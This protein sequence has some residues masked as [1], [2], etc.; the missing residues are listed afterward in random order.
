M[1]FLADILLWESQ[2]LIYI[3]V[4][5]DLGDILTIQSLDVISMSLKIWVTLMILS[6]TLE[7]IGMLVPSRR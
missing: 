6:I 3:M 2:M 1:I 4:I 5:S 7:S